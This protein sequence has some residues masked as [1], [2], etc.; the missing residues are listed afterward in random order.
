MIEITKLFA[1]D[2]LELSCLYGKVENP[3]ALIQ[4]VHGMAEHKERYNELIK[5]L[6]G[7]GFTV[8]ISDLRGH[9]LSVNEKY[10]LGHIESI[11]ELID[12]QL[13]VTDFIKRDNPGVDLYMFSHSFGTCISRNYIMKHDTEIK[14]LILSGTVGY[15]LGCKLG[16]RIGARKM[17]KDKYQMSDLLFSFTNNLSKKEDFGWL[18]VNEENIKVYMEDELCGFKFDVSGYYTLFSSVENLR[19][20]EL[21]E[22]K[23]KDLKILSISGKED[24]TTLGTNGIKSNLRFLNKVGYQNTSF[25]EY[26]NMKHEILQEH[27]NE[28][29][30][31]DI[32][33]FFE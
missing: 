22:C 10:P 30:L 19:K 8:I 2:G 24:R 29:V 33:E 15:N 11:D 6:N 23:N 3:K 21:Y 20:K 7:Y 32:L 31:K 12:D 9:G 26:P 16:S 4:I 5:F 13:I 25:I 27:D 17:K 14:R 1:K 18:S 28:K